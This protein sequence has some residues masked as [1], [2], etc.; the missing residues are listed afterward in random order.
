MYVFGQFK[1][2]KGNDDPK[3]W[4]NV[5]VVKGNTSTILPLTLSLSIYGISSI[6]PGDIFKVDYLPERYK[7]INPNKRAETK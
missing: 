5:E 3:K 7:N 6:I 1:I 2:L 4:K